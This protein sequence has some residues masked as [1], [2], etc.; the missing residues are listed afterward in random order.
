MQPSEIPPSYRDAFNANLDHLEGFA[1][2]TDLLPEYYTNHP[3]LKKI[4]YDNVNTSVWCTH[5]DLSSIYIQT[6]RIALSSI[7]RDNGLDIEL[8][9]VTR[10]VV[11]G[12]GVHVS[13]KIDGYLE[14]LSEFNMRL[15]DSN[16]VPV[17]RID[18][19]YKQYSIVKWSLVNENRRRDPKESEF[20]RRDRNRST[21]EQHEAGLILL[22][23][24]VQYL[25]S[26]AAKSEFKG[27][28]FSIGVFF[29]TICGIVAQDIAERKGPM[30]GMVKH[31]RC[32]PGS[33]RKRAL[34]LGN[35]IKAPLAL[36]PLHLMSIN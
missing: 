21:I 19:T 1:G 27:T 9:N 24:W 25:Y 28:N 15:V 36:P 4:L 29:N 17:Q 5:R 7:A 20:V 16:A 12:V 3:Y 6:F 13:K 10:G 2:Y 23:P 33:S 22:E 18:P 32:A 34:D 11:G 26:K 14:L 30:G 8:L 35:R 31:G